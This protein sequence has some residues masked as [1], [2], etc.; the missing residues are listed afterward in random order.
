[1][2]PDTPGYEERLRVI[3]HLPLSNPGQLKV[4]SQ[5]VTYL[6]SIRET[7][8]DIGVDGFTH[9][10]TLPPVF[11]GYWWSQR[12]KRWVPEGIAVFL[13]DYKVAQAAE[14]GEQVLLLKRKLAEF[15]REST[16]Q[17]EEVWV[18][19]HQILRQE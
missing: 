17:Q 3:C 19:A 4:A 2:A 1:M 7:V 14:V 12:R 18:V 8:T 13:I 5:F 16:N 6:Q 9:S 15:Y 11:R 10:Q